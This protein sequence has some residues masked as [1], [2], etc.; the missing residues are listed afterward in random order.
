MRNTDLA[1]RVLRRFT[2]N[3]RAASIVGDLN[4]AA[5][6]KGAAWFWRSYAGVLVSFAWRP[7]CAF[8]LAALAGYLAN[9]YD[10]VPV[11]SAPIVH[12]G[13]VDLSP[14]IW[15]II[16]VTTLTWMI[17]CYSAIRFGPQ[18]RLTRISLGF[19]VIGTVTG[20]FWWVPAMPIVAAVFSLLLCAYALSSREGRR[21]LAATVALLVGLAII[22]TTTLK[23]FFGV[24]FGFFQHYRIATGIAA[25]SYSCFFVAMALTCASCAWIHGALVVRRDDVASRISDR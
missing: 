5:G 18:D 20:W 2:D 4:E 6:E 13:P 24:L 22:W 12:T 1:E 11:Y 10:G 16:G 21:S 17:A 7:T 23:I 8:A 19:A 14:W 25:W 9:R 15:N 3:L